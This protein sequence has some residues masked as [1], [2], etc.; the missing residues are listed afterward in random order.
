MQ[1]AIT[2]TGLAKQWKAGD[3]KTAALRGVSLQAGAG[4]VTALLGP[5]GAG[6][7]TLIRVLAT[8]L[9]PNSGQAWVGGHDVLR[10]PERVRSLIGLTSQSL[11]VDGK[12]SGPQNLAMFGRLHHLPWPAR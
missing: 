10:E 8:L 6:K 12:L 11:A 9:R 3:G 5:N 2:V 1:P 4:A 7:T